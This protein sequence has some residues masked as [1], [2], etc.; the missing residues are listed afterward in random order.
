MRVDD[1]VNDLL[2]S[3]GVK[4]RDQMVVYRDTLDTATFEMLATTQLAS[5]RDLITRLKTHSSYADVEFVRD[6]VTLKVVHL[7]YAQQLSLRFRCGRKG[8]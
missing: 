1:A 2:D 7:F 6:Q 5:I 8:E 3:F 4:D